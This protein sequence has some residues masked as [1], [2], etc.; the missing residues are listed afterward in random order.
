MFPYK[1][2][3][4]YRISSACSLR[5]SFVGSLVG[6]VSWRNTVKWRVEREV[7]SHWGIFVQN[8]GGLRVDLRNLDVVQKPATLRQC[9]WSHYSLWRLSLWGGAKLTVD[10]EK[11]LTG[12]T[13]HESPVVLLAY[14]KWCIRWCVF[15]FCCLWSWLI[16]EVWPLQEDV[17]FIFVH[18]SFIH[19]QDIQ[20]FQIFISP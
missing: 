6:P 5:G 8:G 15:C 3:G 13:H 10:G 20:I 7:P 9:G 2:V 12:F 11:S 16:F 4:Y 18:V 17:K 1:L 19:I 14:S